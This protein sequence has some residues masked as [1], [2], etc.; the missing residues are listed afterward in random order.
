MNVHRN[1]CLVVISG[2]QKFAIKLQP[3]AHCELVSQHGTSMPCPS[4]YPLHR[5]HERNT[6]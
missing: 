1:R 5:Y 2:V 3:S 6:D 4:L